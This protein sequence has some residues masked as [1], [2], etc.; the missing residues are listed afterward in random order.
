M[1]YSVSKKDNVTLRDYLGKYC[2]NEHI[3]PFEIPRTVQLNME[4]KKRSLTVS[5]GNRQ[6]T[7][8]KKKSTRVTPTSVQKRNKGVKIVPQPTFT[9]AGPIVVDDGIIDL[10]DEKS[11]TENVFL[12]SDNEEMG[13]V[14]T[15]LFGDD[16]DEDLRNNSSQDAID[17]L[18]NIDQCFDNDDAMDRSSD[19]V[20]YSPYK[21]Q[22]LTDHMPALSAMTQQEALDNMFCY[23]HVKRDRVMQ[24]IASQAI[25]AISQI[26][27]TQFTASLDDSATLQLLSD[28]QEDKVLTPSKKWKGKTPEKT[29]TPQVKASPSSLKRKE[30]PGNTPV[31]DEKR[32]KSNSGAAIGLINHKDEE[33]TTSR[34]LTF[35]PENNISTQA[36]MDM[37]LSLAG[38]DNINSSSETQRSADEQLTQS[39]QIERVMHSPP[40]RQTTPNQ[41]HTTQE[42]L[43]STQA[44]MDIPLSL[45]GGS[46]SS[47][48]NDSPKIDLHPSQSSTNNSPSPSEKRSLQMAQHQSMV[49][50]HHTTQS[51]MNMPFSLGINPT[52]EE[53]VL[54]NYSL[55]HSPSRQPSHSEEQE[56]PKT[57]SASPINH[58]TT[59][60]LMN[61]PLSLNGGESTQEQ[62]NPTQSMPQNENVKQGSKE[63]YVY[64]ST[65]SL[66]NMPLSLNG[67]SNSQ[68]SPQRPT[69]PPPQISVETCLSQTPPKTRNVKIDGSPRKYSMPKELSL[70]DEWDNDIYFSQKKQNRQTQSDFPF[71]Q[72]KRKV[73]SLS[74]LPKN[75]SQKKEENK[76]HS[77]PPVVIAVDEN[78]DDDQLSCNMFVD[79]EDDGQTDLFQMFANENARS[80]ST[81]VVEI[82]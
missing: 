58:R 38:G 35:S 43:M 71:A 1:L 77:L 78:D 17:M 63:K 34:V 12:D 28:L 81:N 56:L 15:D 14:L 80:T 21:P 59:M 25:P 26:Q 61:M 4:S 9:Q 76:R 19:D 74:H 47:A 18:A 48:S 20:S 36:L 41:S 54:L 75:N 29:S 57:L 46:S 40:P 31:S 52:E 30:S 6:N 51:L 60:S 50:P 33:E 73:Q 72:K 11:P 10:T 44:L 27:Q 42:Q 16:E 39:P 2:S 65:Q 69:T 13:A 8:T 32:R 68:E 82:D 49:D 70:F 3:A 62:W 53:E 37:T 23:P 66:L 64:Q 24:D 7:S 67:D 22:P 5:G 79:E 45:A 55:R